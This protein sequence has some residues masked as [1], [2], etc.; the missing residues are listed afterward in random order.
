ML[1]RT[2]NGAAAALAVALCG[3]GS[4][5]DQ[6]SAP[7]LADEA[8]FSL[9]AGGAGLEALAP[10]VV[11]GRQDVDVLE[12]E[13]LTAGEF[14]LLLRYRVPGCLRRPTPGDVIQLAGAEVEVV[15]LPAAPAPWPKSTG[16][17]G[18]VR[19]ALSSG[20][21]SGVA[22]G[23]GVYVA[24][25]DPGAGAPP[26]CFVRFE[27]PPQKPPARGVDPNATLTVKFSGPMD[28]ATFE[29][30]GTF[31][32]RRDGPVPPLERLVVADVLAS[33]DLTA[34]TFSPRL[35]LAAGMGPSDY[36]F[37]L[38][39]GPNGVK[40][41]AGAE[42]ASDLPVVRFRAAPAQPVL[43]ASSVSLTFDVL[44]EDGDG[45]PEVR[46][47]VFHDYG[48]G[49]LRARPV[50][51]FSSVV[52]RSQPTLW[53]KQT[54]LFQPPGEAPFSAYGSKLMAVW[55]YHDLGFS[56]LDENYHNLDVEGL[57]WAVDGG[58]ASPDAYAEF[59]MSLAHSRVLPDE[60]IT[61]G[62][63]PSLPVSGLFSQYDA[64][65]L[66]PVADPLTVVSEKAKGYVI[67]PLDQFVAPSGTAMMPWPMNK[68]VAPSEYTY[69]TWRDTGVPNVGGPKGAGADTL[70]LSQLTGYGTL[71]YKVDRV[72]TIAL[73]MLMEFRTYPDATA[74]GSNSIEIAIALN[75][76]ARP[77]FRSFSTGGLLNSGLTKI[78][79][80][81]NEPSATGGVTPNGFA[82]P[83]QDNVFHFG[84]ADFVVRVSRAHTAWLDT[85]GTLS[86]GAPLIEPAVTFAPA[87]TQLV[88]AYR[89]A[90]DITSATWGSWARAENLD[91][92]GNSYTTFQHKVRMSNPA[93][94]FKP[95]WHPA[96]GWTGDLSDLDGARYVQVRITLISN[97]ESGDV[98]RL[99][100][101][102]LPFLR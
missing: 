2:R 7:A 25:W 1:A 10:P 43:D 76:S 64:N 18:N 51:R 77:F 28:L 5:F 40:S 8:V 98:P 16:V 9:R 83:V 101:I 87:G 63:L 11:I 88:L 6:G 46:G 95:I 84:Q 53:H 20:P 13:P 52:D 33:R 67:D 94:K 29:A 78:V 96:A 50:V 26:E 44:D 58:A 85:G 41:L 4:G 27:P 22:P 73:P 100:G 66:D 19:V 97:A 86:F 45:S 21:A 74:L 15:A 79:D 75:S 61:T 68:G 65:L 56:L 49:D 80:P 92:Y 47:Q 82:T 55:R 93:L 81:D 71:F 59:Q 14:L 30:L 36:R 12:V 38:E 23:P 62:L 3:C 17:I 90:S 48:R 57:H 32:V 69:W 91:A 54:W 42:L 60:A 39:G 37:D 89:G 70:A 99:S 102:G 34:V 31:S 35:P 72:P 24:P